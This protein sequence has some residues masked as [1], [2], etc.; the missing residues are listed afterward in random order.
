MEHVPGIMLAAI[1][2]QTEMWAANF[3]P[4]LVFGEK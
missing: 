3:S 2:H 4:R 1:R